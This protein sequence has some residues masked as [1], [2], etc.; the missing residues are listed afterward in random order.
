MPLMRVRTHVSV[1]MAP[2]DEY[3]DWLPC[4]TED[5]VLGLEQRAGAITPL[6]LGTYDVDVQMWTADRFWLLAHGT[7]T[8]ILTSTTDTATV[9]VMME[10]ET[11]G[12]DATEAA[13]AL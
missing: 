9:D 6:E 10:P 5:P 7:S 1:S 3:I 8:A 12:Y 11:G 4:A 2:D 13:G